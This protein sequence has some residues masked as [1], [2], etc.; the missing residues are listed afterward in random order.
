ML[1]SCAEE[2]ILTQDTDVNAEPYDVKEAIQLS[3]QRN[4]E[5]RYMLCP[6]GRCHNADN[7]IIRQGEE[8]VDVAVASGWRLRTSTTPLYS[9]CH[10]MICLST[11]VVFRRHGSVLPAQ[12]FPTLQ[13]KLQ[14][15]VEGDEITVSASRQLRAAQEITCDRWR[16]TAERQLLTSTR[17]Q[18]YCKKILRGTGSKFRAFGLRHTINCK[19]Q[20][21]RPSPYVPS[22]EAYGVSGIYIMFAIIVSDHDAAL[23][24][25][26]SLNFR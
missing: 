11:A 7:S 14:F 4:Y 10:R 1:L 23:D 9:S 6:S 24:M 8:E 21:W 22:A 3:I 12:T 13:T 17:R 18:P 25:S 5:N 20:V 2:G 26:I 19:Q 15:K 16:R